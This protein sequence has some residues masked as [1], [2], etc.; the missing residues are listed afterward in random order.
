MAT[1]ATAS[2]SD[3]FDPPQRVRE[4]STS[5]DDVDPWLSP[6]LHTMVFMSYRTGNGDIYSATR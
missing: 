5:L 4:L 1:F 2:P 6:D 3:P